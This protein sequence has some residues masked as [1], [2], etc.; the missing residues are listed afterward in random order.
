MWKGIYLI[1][2]LILEPGSFSQLVCVGLTEVLFAIF[3]FLTSPSPSHI[4]NAVF[5]IGSVHQLMLLGLVGF[6]TYMRYETGVDLFFVPMLV[7]TLCYLGICGAFIV[8]NLLLPV[9]FSINREKIAKFL[10][11][12]GI[13]FSET[14][15]LY[16][17]CVKKENT[18]ERAS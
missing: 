13:Q 8:Y 6:D 17:I 12:V 4:A 15:N 18:S 14:T 1:A 11:L 16:R 2:P 10:A 5:R 7:L 9:F 3:A